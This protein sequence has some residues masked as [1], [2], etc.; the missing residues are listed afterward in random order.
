[1][2]KINFTI[3]INAPR[4]KVWHTMLDQ[5]TY[6]QWTTAFDPSSRYEGSWEQGAEI[7][8]VGTGADGKE[9]GMY[10]RV[11][12]SRPPEFISIEH[13]G[14][15]EN[16]VIDTTSDKVKAWTP[17]HENYTF[18]EVAGGTEL[19]VEVDVA[20]EY[21]EMFNE[22]WPKALQDLKKLAES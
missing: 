10:S 11:K 7:K 22:M 2:Q 8:F 9:G 17:A 15:I 13:L 14:M 20:D 4:E 19:L 18:N 21:K 12:E 6:R 16:G 5:E 1:M 3:H